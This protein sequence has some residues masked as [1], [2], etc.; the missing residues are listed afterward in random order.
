[1]MKERNKNKKRVPKKNY[2]KKKKKIQNQALQHIFFERY[3][4]LQSFRVSY[5]G[6]FWKWTKDWKKCK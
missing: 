2:K 5:S 3:Q 6:P 1:M 4:H